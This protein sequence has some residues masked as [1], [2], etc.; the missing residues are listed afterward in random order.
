MLNAGNRRGCYVVRGTQ[1]GE[2]QKFS[3]FCPK[4]LAGI[5]NG[6][7]PDTIRDRAIVLAIER[8][9]AGERVDGPVPRRARA[10]TSRSCA[11]GS[12]TGRPSTRTRSPMAALRAASASSTRGC[13]RRGIR[14]SRSPS[15][16]A[17]T[18]R[19][20]RARPRSR[21]PKGGARRRR[22]RRTATC[23]SSRYERS[24]SD[25]RRARVQGDL[26]TRSTRTRSSRSAAT[27]TAP[28]SAARTREAAAGP[29]AIRPEGRAHRRRTPPRATTATSSPRPGRATPPTTRRS[30]TRAAG[31]PKEGSQG[32]HGSHPSPE[33][34]RDV[35]LAT[36]VT[37]STG[38][39]R[40]CCAIT[41]AQRRTVASADD[42]V[43]RYPAAPLERLADVHP[44][45]NPRRPGGSAASA[46]RPPLG[47]DTPNAPQA[48]IE[49]ARL[50]DEA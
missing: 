16:P 27:A 24:S 10:T 6:R 9:A 40:R 20:G 13:R 15:S 43:P 34:K 7:L 8:T 37:A 11:A 33:A 38:R 22:R 12:R 25:A 30:S 29:T 50:R 31:P 18:G 42:A 3:T 19:G 36:P 21:S 32:S 1:D 45:A 14:C 5:D 2:P 4:V 39:L 23:C 35:T 48:T 26:R 46:I 44:R 17:A 47:L 28:G 41:S 49:E